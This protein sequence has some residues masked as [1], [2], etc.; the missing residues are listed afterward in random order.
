MDWTTYLSH[1][2]A[3]ASRLSE[4]AGRGLDVEVPCCEGWTVRT[5]VEHVGD[6]YAE[7][8]AVVD[9]G[10]TERQD[11]RLGMPGDPIVEWFDEAAN[12]LLDVLSDH[13]PAETV[14][15]WFDPDQTVGFWY[16][17]LAH[18]TLIHRIDVEQA[19]GLPSIIDETLAADGIDEVL[20]VYVAGAP[21]WGS[22]AL[23]DRSARLEVPGRSWSV[24]LGRFSGTSPRTG[25]NYMDLP[26]LE[27][28]PGEASS[29]V[30]IS[31]SAG[32]MDR[33]LWGRGSL[34]DLSVTGDRTITEAVRTVAEEST[35]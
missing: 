23:E 19:L 21:A 2:R 11:R 15:T 6:I 14:W 10:W 7:K 17:R 25:S 9:E 31:G 18:E 1:I 5:V 3:D 12:R 32:D 4:I 22:I 26:A 29:H 35:Q 30:E 24:R 28:V 34:D 33:W 8:A 13:E 20:N 16:R 27:L